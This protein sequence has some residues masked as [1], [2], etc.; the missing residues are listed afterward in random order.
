MP[1]FGPADESET[2]LLGCLVKEYLRLWTSDGRALCVRLLHPSTLRGFLARGLAPRV[3]LEAGR[4]REFGRLDPSG[5]LHIARRPFAVEVCDEPPASDALWAAVVEV[6]QDAAAD[7]VARGEY[8]VLERGGW[9][10]KSDNYALA[11]A[12]R[13]PG[14]WL[15]RVEAVPAP[16]APSWPEPPMGLEGWGV[17]APAEP[18]SLA[19]L[20][21]LLADAVAM[22][23]SSPLDIVLTFGKQADGPWPPVETPA[24]IESVLEEIR[25]DIEELHSTRQLSRARDLSKTTDVHFN[26]NTYPLYFT[27]DLLSRLVFVHP[28]P[29]ESQNDAPEYEGGFEYENFDEYLERARRSGHYRWELGREYP[30]PMDYKQM[31]FVKQ[32]GVID[33]EEADTPDD[34]L[35]NLI[36]SVDLKLQLELI[37]YGSPRFPTEGLPAE[38]VAPHYER[39]MRVIT[40]CPRDYVVLLGGV[41]D[42]LFEPYIVDREDHTFRLPTSTGTSRVEYRFSNL[43]L[44]FD[45]GT[46]PAGLAP[47][48]ASPGIPMDA[49]GQTCH[50]LYRAITR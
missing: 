41:F 20:G 43:L 12:T 38:V 4:A 2:V 5:V 10:A 40:A 26:H 32:W 17:A 44:E 46:V 45:G 42:A 24:A 29:Q 50:E 28:N 6:F 36:R 25:A 7:A 23:A 48:F 49:Y 16:R 19:T 3:N 34:Q 22:W 33:F 13:T 8:I 47:H 27:G 15:L 21:A 18:A 14:E 35:T 37:P 1:Q 30:S 31:R 11:G 9:D 39:L